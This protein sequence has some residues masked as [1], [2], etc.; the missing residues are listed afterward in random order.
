MSRD[1]VIRAD[2]LR[3]TV[4]HD[5]L[6]RQVGDQPCGAR[7][8]L[9]QAH[10][11]EQRALTRAAL[12]IQEMSVVARIK[13]RRFKRPIA[14]MTQGAKRHQAQSLLKM[15]SSHS[16]RTMIT[17]RIISSNPLPRQTLRAEMLATATRARPAARSSLR[18]RQ[19]RILRQE[20]T[21]AGRC[22]RN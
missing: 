6:L 9:V 14:R 7:A 8:L 10:H 18:R 19:E 21:T 15:V 5:L 4:L 12:H 13:H 17:Y 1:H 16:V 11:R 2:F 20:N 3:I 22:R